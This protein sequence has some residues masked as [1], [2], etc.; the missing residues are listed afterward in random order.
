MLV[1]RDEPGG[2]SQF[3]WGWIAIRL[4]VDGDSSGRGS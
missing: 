4:G 1:D 3:A 2:G